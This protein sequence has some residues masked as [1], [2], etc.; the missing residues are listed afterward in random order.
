MKNFEKHR[1]VVFQ[2]FILFHQVFSLEW[3]QD[4]TRAPL[5][6]IPTTTTK[7]IKKNPMFS[8]PRDKIASRTMLYGF[9]LFMISSNCLEANVS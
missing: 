2:N 1:G 3:K 8:N 6:V 9:K 4:D 5:I 7:V